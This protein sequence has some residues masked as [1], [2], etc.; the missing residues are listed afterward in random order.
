MNEYRK[1]VLSVLARHPSGAGWYKI[2]QGLSSMTLGARERLPSSLNEL[3]VEGL[4]RRVKN[5]QET[6]VLTD[7]GRHL[8]AA[9]K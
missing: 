1:A 9:G 4:V 5:D 3:E 8:L 7:A 2:E 6:Y